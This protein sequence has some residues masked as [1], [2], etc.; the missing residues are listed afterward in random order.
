MTGKD[1]NLNTNSIQDT[2]K[3]REPGR[4]IIRL[5]THKTHRNTVRH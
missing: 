1:Q 5:D 3:S 4:I 2:G